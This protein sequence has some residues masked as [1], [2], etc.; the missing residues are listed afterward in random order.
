MAYDAKSKRLQILPEKIQG[1]VT[2]PETKDWTPYR[3]TNYYPQFV[4]ETYESSK[5]PD[6]KY[7]QHEDDLI[8]VNV[9]GDDNILITTTYVNSDE[10]Q[11]EV[12]NDLDIP[13]IQIDAAKILK[14]LGFRRGRFKIKFCFYRLMFG[15]PYPLLVNG[16][17][18][19]YFGG[20]EEDDTNKMFALDDHTASE[21]SIGDRVF[22]KED[23]AI[24]TRISSDRTEIV[25]SPNFIN[26]SSYL[27]RFRIAA[28]TCLNDFPIEG[29]G[30]KFA[31]GEDS[32]YLTVVSDNSVS[33]KYI[34]GMIR[35]NDAYFLGKRVVPALN[36][37]IVVEPAFTTEPKPVNLLR[38]RYLDSDYQ[39]RGHSPFPNEDAVNS[40]SQD[41]PTLL[42]T[43]TVVKQTPVGNQC[44]R[45]FYQT[46]ANHS[47]DANHS[48]CL[49]PYLKIHREINNQEFTFSAYVQGVKDSK[50]RL[51]A[52]AGPWGIESTTSRSPLFE[53]TGKWQRISHTFTLSE[54]GE[55]NDVITLRVVI[56]PNGQF[57]PSLETVIGTEYFLAGGQLEIGSSASQFTRNEDESSEEIEIAESGTIKFIDPDSDDPI[58]K[59]T[60]KADLGSG[61][62]IFIQKMVGSNILI[63]DAMTIDDLSSQMVT[64]ELDLREIRHLQP[65]INSSYEIPGSYVGSKSW[66]QLGVDFSFQWDTNL[67]SQAVAQKDEYDRGLWSNG[68]SALNPAGKWSQVGD[69]SVGYHAHWLKDKG[70][71]NELC[72]YFPDLNYLPEILEQRKVLSLAAYNDPVTGYYVRDGLE[73][74]R[75][76][77]D[78][79]NSEGF[80]HRWLSIATG[81]GGQYGDSSAIG[82]LAAYGAKPGDTVRIT[83]Q[84][85][86]IPQNPDFDNGGRKGA[87]VQLLHYYKEVIES[88]STPFITGQDIRNEMIDLITGFYREG[89]TNSL[90]VNVLNNIYDEVNASRKGY[91]SGNGIK[92]YRVE[93]VEGNVNPVAIDNLEMEDEIFA[94]TAAKVSFITKLEDKTELRTVDVSAD[95]P[96]SQMRRTDF[97]FGTRASTN[98]DDTKILGT[99]GRPP[100]AGPTACGYTEF[101]SVTNLSSNISPLGENKPPLPSPSNRPPLDDYNDWNWSGVKWIIDGDL[102]AAGWSYIGQNP[103]GERWV[104]TGINDPENT[105]E[106]FIMPAIVAIGGF[107]YLSEALGWV[108]DGSEWQSMITLLQKESFY[109]VSPS[110]IPFYQSLANGNYE[111]SYTD[112]QPY[113]SSEIINNDITNSPDGNWKWNG[114]QWNYVAGQTE[115]E[116]QTGADGVRSFTKTTLT[117]TLTKNTD[118]TVATRSKGYVTCHELG[119]WEEAHFDFIIPEDNSF[120][121]Y[122]NCGIRMLGHKGGFGELWVDKVRIDILLTSNERIKV[123]QTAKL[124]P[125]LLKIEEVLENDTIVVEQTYDEAA[126]EQGRVDANIPVNKY[127]SFGGGYEVGYVEE[128][129]VIEDIMARYEGKILDI[130][131]NKL[132]VDKS[133][134]EFGGTINAISGSVDSP[135]IEHQFNDYFVRYRLKDSDNLY[136]KVVFG[137]DVESVVV[138]FKPVNATNYPGSIA[139]KLL[140]PLSDEITEFD[141]AYIASEVTPD[142][143]ETVD[144]VP[145]IDEVI[146]DTVLKAPKLSE[147]EPVIVKRETEYRSHT[148]LVGVNTDVRQQLEDKIFSGSL[149]DVSINV[150]YSIF[151]NFSHFGSVEK[152]VNNFKDKLETIELYTQ[153]SQSLGGTSQTPYI[154]GQTSGSIVS[155]S[156]DQMKFWN[157]EKRKVINGFDDFENYMFNVS[158]SYIS[159]SNGIEYDNAAP[160]FSG[161]GT[162]TNPY[163]LFS[164]SSSEFTT[165]HTNLISSASVFD[166]KNTNRL[167]NLIPAHVTYDVDNEPF[168]RFMD[169][170]G[171]HYD[172]IW[173]HIKAMTDVHERSEDITKGISAQLVQPVAESLG[174]TMLE[175]RDLVRMPQYHLGLSESGSRTGEFNIRFTKKSQQ[176]VTREIWNRI[177]STM[178]YIL[179]T[180]GTKQS[181]KALIAA[182]GIPTSILRIQ[183]YGGPKIEGGSPEFEIK[184]RYTYALD[185]HGSQR[186]ASPWYRNTLTDRTSDTIEFRFKTG[187]ERNTLIATKNN[188]SNMVES[189]IYIHNV[190]GSD[191]KGKLAFALSGS[192]GFVT[193]SL[194]PLP[195][196]NNE[197]WSVM[198]RRRQASISS[199]YSEQSLTGET[200]QATHSFDIY[201]GFYDSGT[202][203]IITKASASMT[204]SGSSLLASWYASSSIGDNYWQIGGKTQTSEENTLYGSKF[205]GSIMEWRYWSTPLKEAAF[206]NHVSAPKAINGNHESSSFYDMN[207]RF[208][209]DDKANLNSSPNVVRDY[210][211]TGGQV[212]ATGSGFANAINFSSVS[213]RQKGFIPSIGLNKTS[214]KLRLDNRKT[215]YSDGVPP[216]LST[217]ERVELSSYDTAPLDSNKLGIFF[218]PSD[219]INEDII[220]SLADLDFG[221]YLGD[222]R[223]TYADRYYHGRLDR[224]SDT[225]WKKWTTKFNFWDYLKLI[226]YYDLS[227]FDHLRKLSPARAKKNIGILIEPTLLERPKVIVGNKPFV[228]ERNYRGRIRHYTLYSQSAAEYTKSGSINLP[229][230]GLLTSSNDMYTSQMSGKVYSLDT[231]SY[232]SRTS[233]LNILS[234]RKYTSSRDD[235]ASHFKWSYEANVPLT[236]SKDDYE[237]I[238]NAN[239]FNYEQFRGFKVDPLIDPLERNYT[240]GE[241][242]SGGGGNI[243]HEVLMPMATSSVKSALND[244]RIYHYSSSVSKSLNLWYSS[245]FEKS[246][247]ESL[248]TS[249]TG[250]FN[251]MYGGCL[252]N[253]DTI[254]DGNKIAVEITE[255]NPYRVTSRRSGDSF[256]DVQ[257]DNE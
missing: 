69:A 146:P 119:E 143:V 252:E 89:L 250:M 28:Y 105:G 26:D 53:V 184:Q 145:F 210:S 58:I 110:T 213:D 122:T 239:R 123:D 83:W 81:V 191:T 50:V 1:L 112:V 133:Y 116:L 9:Y 61:D 18:K 226:K 114:V 101:G 193:A 76:T 124:G 41:N 242:Y 243:F 161:D 19:I 74:P 129:E 23:K 221:S 12:D 187:I 253:G 102:V 113:P 87:Q 65:Y 77:G 120:G 172:I 15:S 159:S 68:F 100:A 7:G 44:V 93:I 177:L 57:N 21:T 98:E 79:I 48:F 215:I 234:H 91:A 174:F 62:E 24:L 64:N 121:L 197:Y 6:L 134:R 178:P 22:S 54:V 204:L 212:Y 173:T 158:S 55:G 207:L 223:D 34:N 140:E 42:G 70:V 10:F 33:R 192:E 80:K 225:Y 127:T 36:A 208:S 137:G 126:D 84:Q 190:S 254:P 189:A 85:K 97:I 90:I 238:A 240:E 73:D 182:Y 167:I 256:V 94:V 160:K 125:I 198:V 46:T 17:E 163:K 107:V 162:L 251:L 27:E 128:D 219:V 45:V 241:V 175:G 149:L 40:I 205:S 66:T 20:F 179:K 156:S 4:S 157:M 103:V 52:H 201:A 233:K 25:L 111:T 49:S 196:Y 5:W 176:D 13:V 246:E 257:L 222:P 117:D 51:L 244:D 75:I 95:V 180:K 2:L 166:R 39:W 249:H 152:R 206:F 164:V 47:T 88:P 30:V 151:E 209:M 169:M 130:E 232:E 183:E 139:Y 216:V 144:L 235:M 115:E 185:F 78:V 72:M 43:E 199:S 86:A 217:T 188:S 229:F 165:W 195:F 147:I 211:L 63:R 99:S 131:G 104:Q 56:Y 37:S 108:W 135:N 109:Y 59:R 230:D 148:D 31:D 106:G 214:N 181:L 245:S 141:S 82:A 16:E 231:G 32:N 224:I 38:G 14:D 71:D 35:I 3:D 67:H 218:A 194:Q 96:D 142:L 203:E 154:T 29:E 168:I 92:N 60:L 255:V 247:K 171:H 118:G 227:L 200:T 202:D 186:L 170:M 132:I 8:K 11:S 228:E 237:S 248:F 155:G 150:D 236:S 138:N 136:T 220:L 153:K